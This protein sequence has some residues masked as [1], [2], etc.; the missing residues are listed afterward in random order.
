MNI[1]TKFVPDLGTTIIGNPDECIALLDANKPLP[2]NDL[3]DYFIEKA[4]LG[5]CGNDKLSR[6]CLK[7]YA[8]YLMSHHVIYPIKGDVINFVYQNREMDFY[9]IDML[10]FS[11]SYFTKYVQRN[12]NRVFGGIF[13]GKHIS[14]TIDFAED[15]LIYHEHVNYSYGKPKKDKN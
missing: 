13:A 12:F 9:K 10:F 5:N 8:E 7:M 4:K 3:M 11:A 1:Y 15:D 2:Y 6:I 14:R